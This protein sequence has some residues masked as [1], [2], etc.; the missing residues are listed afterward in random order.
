MSEDNIFLEA[1]QFDD[2]ISNEK[3]LNQNSSVW[4]IPTTTEM[5]D[6][7][8]CLKEEVL[9]AKCARK[10]PFV[11][12]TGVKMHESNS[13]H[14]N[15]TLSILDAALIYLFGGD[16]YDLVNL[17]EGYDYRDIIN[18]AKRLNLFYNKFENPT[19]EQIQ[20]YEI[21]HSLYVPSWNERREL[22]IKRL[23]RETRGQSSEIG[24]IIFLSDIVADIV[25]H[26]E[27]NVLD[28]VIVASRK[29]A[30][31]ESVHYDYKYRGGF[32]VS[33]IL[34]KEYFDKFAKYDDHGFFTAIVVMITLQ[35]NGRW[36][37]W[38][39]ELYDK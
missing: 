5:Y 13:S 7:C 4:F 11:D 2:L 22:E 8:L 10:I 32:Y 26:T 20:K 12:Q 27:S 34:A 24:R 31:D 19:P 37:S 29:I 39:E 25:Y 35:T 17:P 14:T 30:K 23:L 33:E 3:R 36:F 15:L 1:G 9:S 6:F 38:R 16:D 18:T 21:T 28:P